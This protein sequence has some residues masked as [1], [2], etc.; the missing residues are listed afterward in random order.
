MQSPPRPLTLGLRSAP[1]FDKALG[2]ATLMNCFAE[3]MGGDAKSEWPILAVPG[4][5]TWLTFSAGACRGLFKVNDTYAL[6]VFGIEIIEIQRSGA[7]RSVGGIAG[8]DV[9]TFG[10]NQKP[11]G[12]EVAVVSPSG[13]RMYTVGGA[14]VEI[15]DSDLPDCIGCDA[16][17]S[18]VLYFVADGRVFYSDLNNAASISALSFFTAE[19]RADGLVRGIVVNGQLWLFGRY[20]AE[21]WTLSDDAD[22][23]F[24]RLPGAAVE[25]GCLASASVVKVQ[26]PG[27]TRLAW[28]ANDRTVRLSNGYNGDRISDHSVERDI[29]RAADASVIEGHSY[30]IDGHCFI[31]FSCHEW[32]WVFNTTT[33]LWHQEQT[34]GTTRRRTSH[35]IDFNGKTYCGDVERPRLMEIG[36]AY[37]DDD[38]TQLVARIVTP[39]DHAYPN[40]I[41]YNALYVDTI[42]GTG[43]NVSAPE[44]SDPQI[45]VR[46]S[47]DGGENFGPRLYRSTGKV[48]EKRKRVTINRLG[49][50]SEDGMVLELE[51]AS[52]V[53]RGISSA[54]VDAVTVRA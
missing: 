9:V 51:W 48:G 36:S 20:S 13:K 16:L 4:L 29:A 14:A 28:V 47:W 39:P 38:G 18:Y 42:P 26:T 50:S 32:T 25:Q 22:R 33:T 44:L 17:A 8:D 15:T 6:A 37:H 10:A 12:A 2:S 11:A 46:W 1:G 24:I 52:S 7:W 35:A 45:S 34:Y 43:L 49:T 21:I 53:V 23:P 3:Q 31:R 30:T 54:A 5:Q 19:S 27:A 41:E 40:E